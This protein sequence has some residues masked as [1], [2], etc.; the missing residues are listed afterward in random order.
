M[1]KQFLIL[2]GLA[3]ALRLPFLNQA[4]QGDDLYYLYGAE[5]AQI[6]PLHPTHTQYLFLGDLVD[7]RGQSHPPLNSWILG[8]LLA[9]A[10]DVREA[11]FH[12]AYALF[13]IISVW[14]MWS[15]ARRFSSRP[16]LATLLFCAVPAFIVNGNS[17]ESDLPFLAFW[18]SAVALFA[19][20]VDRGSL[21]ALAG[22]AAAAGLAALAAY[23]GIFLMPILAAFLW[24]KRRDWVAGWAAI[25]A[26]PAILA[27][28]QIW[29]RATGGALPASMLAGYLSAY[30]FESLKRKTHAVVALV[31]HLGWI[32]SPLIVLGAMT[33][34]AR[35]QW[36]VAAAAA[37]GAAI[38]DPNPLFWIGFAC[39]AWLLAWCFGRGFPGAWV[40]IFFACG[41]AVFFVGSARYLLPLAAPVAILLVEAVPRSLAAAGFVLQM[42]L[43][44]GLAVVNYQ[45]SNAYRDVAASLLRETAPRRVWIDADWGL[46]WYLEAG[47]GLPLPKNQ[48]V[49]P[50]EIVIA[51]ELG[52]PLRPGVPLAPLAQ[53]EIS[54]RIPLRLISLSGRS[55]YSSGRGFLPFEISRGPIDRIQAGIAIEPRL[56]YVDPKLP[57]ASSQIVSGLSVDGWM[58]GEAKLLLKAPDHTEP[59]EVSFYV[60]ANAPTRRL[61]VY[62]SGAL[63]IDKEIPGPGLYTA[64]A[65]VSSSA[66]SLTITLQADKTFSAAGDARVLGVVIQGVGFR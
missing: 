10:G 48:I 59:L 8:L 65:P 54:P 3:L 31:V 2:A 23:Q 28:W 35:W 39:G 49:Q 24:Q 30:D 20:A 66:S 4:I 33:R 17:L 16:A 21:A 26:A 55:A 14:A 1:V 46:R 44:L 57:D 43:A 42:G 11:P 47:G 32:A 25:F 41:A 13:S 63:A 15:L 19:L 7:M 52:N 9:V 56:S 53:A 62:A 40:L 64:S 29:E 36:A 34:S 51:S 37:I 12:L 6:D 5:H 27:A 22:S 61:R 45:H 58:A 18:M 38:Y 60:P 50:G